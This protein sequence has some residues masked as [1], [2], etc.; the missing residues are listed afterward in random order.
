MVLCEVGG[1][2]CMLLLKTLHSHHQITLGAVGLVL[3]LLRYVKTCGDFFS[4]T[5]LAR[6]V[7]QVV[8]GAP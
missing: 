3:L 1:H 8:S 7:V 5:R 4:A 2:A 6:A